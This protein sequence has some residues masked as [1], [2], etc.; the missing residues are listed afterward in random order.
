MKKGKWNYSEEIYYKV[1]LV[2]IAEQHD[3]PMSWQN[4]F[5]GMVRQAVAIESE[6][7]QHRFLI[8]NEDGT[9]LLKIL[10]GGGPDSYSAHIGIHEIIEDVPESEWIQYDPVLHKRQRG[11]VDAW[12]QANFPEDFAR[13]QK[14]RDMIVSRN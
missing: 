10:R 2:R 3:T 7:G 14:L 13:M 11:M 1:V 9:G 8:D 12:Q 4:A 6:G 5:A